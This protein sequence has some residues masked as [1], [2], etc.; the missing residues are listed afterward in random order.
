[1][2]CLCGLVPSVDITIYRSNTSKEGLKVRDYFNRKGVC[3]EDF[4]ISSDPQA[5]QKIK[6]LSGQTEQPVV[7]VND[8]V[9]VGFNPEQLNLAVP[10]RYA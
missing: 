9:F 4:D 6:E 1:M 5:F 8:K 10:S 7:V 3:Y 2:P